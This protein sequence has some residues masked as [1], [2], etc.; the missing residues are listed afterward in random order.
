MKK[1]FEEFK[2]FILRG[3]VLDLAVAVIVGGAFQQIVNSLV[4]D[5]IS[6]I[7]GLFG[8]ADFSEFVLIINN[9]EIKYGAFFTA[10]IQFLI[11]SF[12]I[13]LL[14]KLINKVMQTGKKE[15][16]LSTKKCVYCITDIDLKA[17]KCPNCTA[18]LPKGNL[19]V[20]IEEK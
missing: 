18:D 2:A 6:P 11:M 4:N 14:I 5:I 9:V 17:T 10:I 12:I 1:F 16:K 15:E 7:I 20:E 3:N 13:F 19:K 8:K